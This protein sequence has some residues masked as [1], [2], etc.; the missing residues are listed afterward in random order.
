MIIKEY[1]ETRE[2]GVKLY[3]SYSDENKYIIK[4]QTGAYY[5]V[6]VD[7]ED[8]PYTYIESDKLIKK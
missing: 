7:V 4:E 5:S 3:K 8:S 2:D 6:A 1:Y